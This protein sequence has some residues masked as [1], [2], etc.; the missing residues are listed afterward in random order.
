MTSNKPLEILVVVV[1]VLNVSVDYRDPLSLREL[2]GISPSVRGDIFCLFSVKSMAG[3]G[4]LGISFIS[5]IP[6]P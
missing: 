2:S 6:L 3:L 5:D 1:L 4:R